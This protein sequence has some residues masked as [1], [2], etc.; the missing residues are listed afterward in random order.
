VH[1]GECDADGQLAS[2]ELLAVDGGEG[3][4]LGVLV[5][6]LDETVALGAAVGALDD[7]GLLDVELVV[8]EDLGE[9]GVVH[10]EGQVRDEEHG[11]GRRAVLLGW[12]VLA[13]LTLLALLLA[14]TLL[15][16]VVGAFGATTATA[17]ARSTA[18][19]SASATGSASATTACTVAAFGVVGLGL[20]TWLC[21]L[22]V[23]LTS[24]Q[25]LLVHGLDGALGVLDG[26]HLDE[27]VAER[28]SLV[29][30]NDVGTD[31]LAAGALELRL[32]V[33]VLGLE[34]QVADKDLDGGSS[35]RRCS[36]S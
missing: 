36:A 21:E 33:G 10:R 3:L 29:V 4:L 11:L 24:V 19:S 2:L 26:C 23:D 27:T 9:R 16:I 15:A 7:G 5:F 1:L 31:N 8:G 28:A 17:T 6:E 22:D 25:F 14:L 18:S 34:R 35:R 32:Q 13:W 20:V 12:S 30:A